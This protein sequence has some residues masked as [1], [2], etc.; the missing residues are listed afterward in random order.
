MTGALILLALLALAL[1]AHRVRC[2]WAPFTTKG[3][4]RL[5]YR[6]RTWWAGGQAE[7]RDEH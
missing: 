1:L 5:L 4:R 2:A 3:R 6:R 7:N